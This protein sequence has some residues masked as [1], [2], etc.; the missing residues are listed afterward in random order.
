MISSPLKNDTGLDKDSIAKAIVSS[1][2]LSNFHIESFVEAVASGVVNG[3]ITEISGIHSLNRKPKKQSHDNQDETIFESSG[4]DN[5]NLED[6][7]EHMESQNPISVPDV[8]LVFANRKEWPENSAKKF[9]REHNAQEM[10]RGGGLSA[11]SLT[12][13]GSPLSAV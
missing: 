2:E 8:E 9:Q 1:G 6:I 5:W 3:D 4:G 10:E 13:T 11:L 12:K 7:P